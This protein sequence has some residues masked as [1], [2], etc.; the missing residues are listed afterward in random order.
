MTVDKVKTLHVL[1]LF[2]VIYKGCSLGYKKQQQTTSDKQASFKGYR[3]FLVMKRQQQ[4]YGLPLVPASAYSVDL[5]KLTQSEVVDFFYNTLNATSETNKEQMLEMIR[6]VF[7]SACDSSMLTDAFATM[8]PADKQTQV[9]DIQAPDAIPFTGVINAPLYVSQQVEEMDKDFDVKARDPSGQLAPGNFTYV[10]QPWKGWKEIYCYCEWPTNVAYTLVGAD[11][12]AGPTLCTQLP[13][14]SAAQY[15]DVSS[16]WLAPYGIPTFLLPPALKT[17]SIFATANQVFSATK[18]GSAVGAPYGS[19]SASVAQMYNCTQPSPLGFNF[20]PYITTDQSNPTQWTRANG[21][22]WNPGSIIPIIPKGQGNSATYN[23]ILIAAPPAYQITPGIQLD[24]NY[25]MGRILSLF[26][27]CSVSP[28]AAGTNANGKVQI[29]LLSDAIQPSFTPAILKQQGGKNYIFTTLTESTD[30]KTG[31]NIGGGTYCLGSNVLQQ[32]KPLTDELEAGYGDGGMTTVPI[33][34]PLPAHGCCNSMLPITGADWYAGSGQFQEVGPGP[35]TGPLPL[36]ANQGGQVEYPVNVYNGLTTAVAGNTLSAVVQAGGMGTPGSAAG[37]GT[38]PIPSGLGA[39]GSSIPYLFGSAALS[40]G[41]CDTLDTNAESI[42]AAH[43]ETALGTSYALQG[44]RKNWTGS[45]ASGANQNNICRITGWNWQGLINGNEQPGAADVNQQFPFAKNMVTDN[46]GGAF[47][48]MGCF[49][50]CVQPTGNSTYARMKASEDSDFLVGN[51]VSGMTKHTPFSGERVTQQKIASVPI[52]RPPEGLPPVFDFTWTIGPGATRACSLGSG[53]HLYVRSNVN[54][55]IEQIEVP[56]SL[57][58]WPGSASMSTFGNQQPRPQDLQALSADAVSTLYS[59]V[60]NLPYPDF[61]ALL[62]GVGGD[63]VAGGMFEQERVRIAVPR[64]PAG[65][66]PSDGS[67]W[68]YIATYVGLMGMT[69]AKCS[70]AVTLR[71]PRYYDT[72][73][74]GPAYVTLVQGLTEGQQ[75]SLKLQ[76][77]HQVVANAATAALGLAAP[78]AYS[79]P[80]LVNM[81]FT[82]LV[83]ALFANP[84]SQFFRVVKTNADFRRQVYKLYSINTI[85]EFFSEIVGNDTAFQSDDSI[86]ALAIKA[87]SDAATHHGAQQV[88]HGAIADRVQS[89]L[90]EL[91]Q[92]EIHDAMQKVQRSAEASARDAVGDAVSG[93]EDKIE[94]AVKRHR[95]DTSAIQD[96]MQKVQRSAEASARDAVEDAVSGIE[97]KIESAIKRHQVDRAI[98]GGGQIGARGQI[99]AYGDPGMIGAG[100]SYVDPEDMDD[101]I[102]DDEE[103][104][105]ECHQ[106]EAGGVAYDQSTQTFISVLGSANSIAGMR[107]NGTPFVT[108]S[109]FKKAYSVVKGLNGKTLE[110]SLS[111]DAQYGNEKLHFVPID[112]ALEQMVAV[113]KSGAPRG[114]IVNQDSVLTFVQD[115]NAVVSWLKQ[116]RQADKLKEDEYYGMR[117]KS[118]LVRL[119]ATYPEA[120]DEFAKKRR[121]SFTRNGK[122]RYGHFVPVWNYG[123]VE[124]SQ[125]VILSGYQ[126]M[127]IRRVH[128]EGMKPRGK[129]VQELIFKINEK[130]QVSNQDGRDSLWL[131]Y[132]ETVASFVCMTNNW[133]EDAYKRMFFAAKDRPAT[134]VAIARVPKYT[135]VSKGSAYE[136]FMKRN[137]PSFAQSAQS[138]AAEFEEPFLAKTRSSTAASAASAARAASAFAPKGA[139]STSAQ[140]QSKGAFSRAGAEQLKNL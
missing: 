102:T 55:V 106:V 46:F 82:R 40:F 60:G 107:V 41:L 7:V 24:Q 13:L 62:N 42:Y 49:S 124:T 86:K 57:K 128:K 103:A 3:Y 70:C 111:G 21:Y 119:N 135:K 97:D 31:T 59:N 115:T 88:D 137:G 110:Q 94:S 90:H 74:I 120:M 113:V 10:H 114:A 133:D 104:G 9:I 91:I 6:S 96:A 100:G 109:R 58:R 127:K 98:H 54:G 25:T 131:Q 140:S 87:V 132:F 20:G 78:S 23:S 101:D 36:A 139:G 138:Q 11:I 53:F 129:S 56:F 83:E 17:D 65:V 81:S 112:E 116:N 38:P 77:F 105:G 43:Q 95:V 50:H 61:G 89:Q 80:P 117:A 18:C 27:S 93:I 2:V 73:V 130:G 35:A 136:E 126:W 64:F 48:W 45:A 99:G 72:G 28:N 39:A 26:F 79:Q 71:Y 108:E 52:P 5:S 51:W 14:G 19:L 67:K 69:D 122:P 68:T 22:L 44:L 16:S 47:S 121:D 76:Q 85:E 12:G 66:N 37:S 33:V 15:D 123:C 75:F 4:S 84:K 8:V 29:A 134:A 63:I 118:N 125:K 32:L 30:V 34:I 92:S 1:L